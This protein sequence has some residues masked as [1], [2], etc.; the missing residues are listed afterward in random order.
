M[1]SNFFLQIKT[2]DDRAVVIDDLLRMQNSFYSV[3]PFSREQLLSSL[4]FQFGKQL[5]SLMD[6]AEDKHRALNEL[7]EAV[8]AMKIVELVV[9]YSPSNV[10]AEELVKTVKKLW[11]DR[12][13][14]RLQVD[15]GMCGGVRITV[16]GKY[17]DMSLVSA[18]SHYWEAHRDYWV[19]RF[20]LQ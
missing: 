18:L 19:T 13:L 7:K 15:I 3:Q 16:D 14:V 2:V 1:D 4:S 10:Q 9:G 20:G 17:Q 11:G 5:V 8:E 12:V 6:R